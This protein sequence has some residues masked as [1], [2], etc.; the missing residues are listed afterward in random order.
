MK[1]NNI[2]RISIL[3]LII[4]TVMALADPQK[5]NKGQGKSEGKEKNEA[6]KGRSDDQ[7]NKNQGQDNGKGKNQ[8][9]GQDNNNN[10]ANKNKEEKGRQDDE[11]RDK[12][13]DKDDKDNS[14]KNISKSDRGNWEIRRGKGNSKVMNGKRDV[15][16][17]WGFDNWAQRKY[18][19]NQKKVTI[20]HN[21]S[22]DGSGNSVT[23]NI[24][25]NA[26]QAHL[27]HGDQIGNCTNNYSDRWS[28]GYIQSR[29]D[30]YNRYEQTYETMSYSEA[31]LKYALE[32]LLGVRTNLNT[33]RVNL[34]SQEVQRREG[35]ILDLQNNVTDLENQLSLSRNRLDSDVNIIVQ[36]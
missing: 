31:L 5:D 2:L 33:N 4:L 10:Q 7:G 20:C 13:R 34:S 25:E 1:R 12:G 36:L 3:P 30:V 27:N 23:I 8:D 29:E 17:D 9:N 26:V 11:Q 35:L 21:P 22:G 14:G 19:K 6:A 32:K 28:P 18:P 15:D 16:I 24:S